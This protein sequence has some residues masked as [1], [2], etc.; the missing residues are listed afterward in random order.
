MKKNLF[1]VAAVALM[2]MVS[3]NKEEIGNS[4]VQAG[5]ASNIV[6]SAE[7]E[8]P[9]A[10]AA[11]QTPAE[12]QTK[13]SLGTTTGD[14]TSVNWVAGDK[15]KINGV[16]FS[17]TESGT[18][19]DFTTTASFTEA[20]T[21]Y[22]VYPATAAGAADHSTVTIPASQKG[23]FAEAAISV[24]KSNTQS[25]HFKNVASIIKFRVPAAASKVTITSSDDLAGTFSVTFE[26]GLPKIGTVTSASK[27]ITVTAS[28]QANTDYYVAVLPGDKSNLIVSIDGYHSKTSKSSVAPTRASMLNLQTLPAKTASSWKILG[29]YNSWSWT[30][31][32][33]MYNEGLVVVK[34]VKLSEQN[35]RA[36]K[37]CFNN[38]SGQIGA[39]GGNDSKADHQAKLGEWYG[40]EY[41][42]DSFKADF[43]LPDYNKFYDV[44]I[45]VDAADVWFAEAGSNA[46]TVWYVNGIDGEWGKGIG[47]VGENDC[48][49]ARNVTVNNDCSFKFS[50]RNG[51]W[52]GGGT[53]KDGEYVSTGGN[54]IS[55]TKGTYNI[56]LN[57]DRN[58]FMVQKIK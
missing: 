35:N 26:N 28:F 54:N 33:Q 7:L 56:F 55:I 43:V 12:A 22:A 36:F 9:G 1:M 46:P 15:V 57:S 41:N 18:R 52:I 23:T 29:G 50:S 19:T 58:K 13:T 20:E 27:T 48:F 11:E 24:A 49:A 34:N 53:L 42:S 21:Y 45:D 37:F 38:W 16:E 32:T 14:V 51:T 30:N 17:A 25:L 44:Y 8:Q 5:A 3:C 47:M 10:P 31:G 2:A 4:G 40:S 6:F 39:Y